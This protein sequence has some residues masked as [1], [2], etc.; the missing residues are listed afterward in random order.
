MDNAYNKAVEIRKWVDEHL[1]DLAH[2][3]GCE[4]PND[5]QGP[6]G[7]SACTLEDMIAKA[8]RKGTK[9]I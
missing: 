5:K 9:P 8:I 3:S 4:A 2:A 1:C 7:C 6:S